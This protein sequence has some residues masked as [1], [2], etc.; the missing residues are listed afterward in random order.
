MDRRFEKIQETDSLE[1]LQ[2]RGE[3]QLQ[4][5]ASELDQLREQMNTTITEVRQRSRSM[6]VA[7]SDLATRLQAA[8]LVEESRSLLQAPSA[9]GL[10]LAAQQL[11]VDHR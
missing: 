2:R 1:D 4:F 6:R 7:V 8:G 3:Q 5:M 10:E 11:G 9:D